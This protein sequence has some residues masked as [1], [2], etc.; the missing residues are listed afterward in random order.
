MRVPF[1]FVDGRCG[2]ALMA[3][4]ALPKEYGG[5][6]HWIHCSLVTRGVCW[7]ATPTMVVWLVYNGMMRKWGWWW[8]CTKN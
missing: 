6:W 4:S 3:A 8:C 7:W 1:C 5:V 2:S